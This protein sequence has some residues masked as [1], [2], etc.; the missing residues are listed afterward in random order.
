MAIQC[1]THNKKT[2]AVCHH[3]GKPLCELEGLPLPRGSRPTTRDVCGYAIIDEVFHARAGARGTEAF[4]CESCLLEQHPDY[5]QHVQ[6]LRSM[7][8]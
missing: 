3:C 4:H 5:T 1:E 8:P 6:R 2:K 7:L